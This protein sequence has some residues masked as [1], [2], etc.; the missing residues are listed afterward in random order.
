MGDIYLKQGKRGEALQAYQQARANAPAGHQVNMASAL[1]GLA[2]VYALHGER[3]LAHDYGN[4]SYHLFMEAKAPQSA[5]V[6]CWLQHNN[7][8]LMEAW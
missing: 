1:F 2:Q 5:Q 6:K 3:A 8:P 4:Q 7:L